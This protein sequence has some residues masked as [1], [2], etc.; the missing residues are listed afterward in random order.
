MNLLDELLNAV[1]DL[2]AQSGVHVGI[3][4]L[5]AI[6]FALVGVIALQLVIGVVRTAVNT[7]GAVFGFARTQV[8]GKFWQ[9]AGKLTT[10]ISFALLVIAYGLYGRQQSR[11]LTQA[12]RSMAEDR[13]TEI[14]PLTVLTQV[15]LLCG[16]WIVFGVV[17]R[18]PRQTLLEPFWIVL[19][20]VACMSVAIA[21]SVGVLLITRGDVASAL[22]LTAA[23][24]A[25]GCGVILIVAKTQQRRADAD[26]RDPGGT[27]PE[28]TQGHIA[29]LVL[30]TLLG[31]ALT[32]LYSGVA[33]TPSVDG[34]LRFDFALLAAMVLIACYRFRAYMDDAEVPSALPHLIDFSLALSA[35]AIA[36]TKARDAEVTLGGV[37]PWVIVVGPPLII[38]AMIFAVHLRR[39]L[40]AIPNWRTCL[41]VAL[42]GGL[43]VGPAQYAL[44]SELV[45][46]VQWLPLPRL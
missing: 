25:V 34:L 10:F 23:T 17:A 12:L 15:A 16:F 39:H 24:L 8:E 28:Q 20:L 6:V 2:L 19:A 4:T 40:P 11:P 5:R 21:G 1:A 30:C 44:A 29:V 32:A 9:D 26:G 22:F 14:L 45:P 35:C 42:V 31:S 37:P 38:A 33:R 43:L 13:L 36:L 41:V 7:G 3:G 18:V 46:V 27:G